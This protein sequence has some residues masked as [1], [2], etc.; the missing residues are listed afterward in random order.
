MATIESGHS[1]SVH[2]HAALE[3]RERDSTASTAA[4]HPP[5]AAL[6]AVV[7][8]LTAGAVVKLLRELQFVACAKGKCHEWALTTCVL[9]NNTPSL[10]RA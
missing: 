4:A 7:P 3:G 9:V 6:E 2:S 10:P 5:F 8:D 1:T